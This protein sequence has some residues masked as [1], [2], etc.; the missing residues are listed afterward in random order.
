MM[1]ECFF[2]PWTSPKT[3][4][5]HPWVLPAQDG[6]TE[7]GVWACKRCELT[8]EFGLHP[9]KT[10]PTPSKEA[11]QDGGSQNPNFPAGESPTAIGQ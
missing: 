5:W 2:S 8:P 10:I 7:E 3:S 1:G 4:P 11:V 9:L 6:V